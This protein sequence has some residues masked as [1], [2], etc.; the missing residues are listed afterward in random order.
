MRT[1][2]IF[3]R[4]LSPSCEILRTRMVNTTQG[5]RFGGRG[6]KGWGQFVLTG[7]HFVA[8]SPPMFRLKTFYPIQSIHWL[9]S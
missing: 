3:F 2:D 5:Q 6:Q 4:K 1:G 9:L 7:G 8:G